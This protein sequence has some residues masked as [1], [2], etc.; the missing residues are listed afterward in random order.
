MN[1]EAA[2]IKMLHMTFTKPEIANFN[3]ISY[4]ALKI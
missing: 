2:W 1:K 4:A 3:T